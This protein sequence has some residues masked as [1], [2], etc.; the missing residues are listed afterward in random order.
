MLQKCIYTIA[1]HNGTV[2][3]NSVECY[4]PLTDQWTKISSISK[5]RRFATATTVHDK[6]IV[7]GGFGDMTVTTIEPSSEMF[8]LRTKQWSL[9][10][11][12]LNPRAAHGIVSVDDTVYMFGGEN[13]KFYA[14]GVECFKVNDS[15]WEEAGSIPVQAS[16]FGTSLLKLPKEFIL[17][18][19]AH[20]PC[21]GN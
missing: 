17:N 1:G 21:L 12:P 13:E 16:Y 3:Q 15:E 8:D 18:Q 5:V 14:D 4:N 7:V 11:S 9:V 20:L 10:S 6:I 19:E 2:C